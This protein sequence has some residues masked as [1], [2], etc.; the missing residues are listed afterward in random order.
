LL[1]RAIFQ[2]RKRKVRNTKH[3]LR[4]LCQEQYKGTKNLK[5]EG[6]KVSSETPAVS[7]PIGEGNAKGPEIHQTLWLHNWAHVLW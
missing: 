5:K 7:T 4:G 1:E 3:C 2:N 6:K